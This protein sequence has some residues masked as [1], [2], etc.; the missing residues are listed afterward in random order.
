MFRN[1]YYIQDNFRISRSISEFPRY[2]TELANR[3][4]DKNTVT[5][6]GDSGPTISFDQ[7]TNQISDR[8]LLADYSLHNSNSSCTTSVFGFT[9][10]TNS[11]SAFERL[12]RGE[13]RSFRTGR[14]G[15]ELMCTKLKS[16]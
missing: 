8:L 11:R 16:A 6:Q 14:L 7:D 13:N 15:T 2:D 3:E 10:S 1:Q 5:V 9:T 4:S 12:A